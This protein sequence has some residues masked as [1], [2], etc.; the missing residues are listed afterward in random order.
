MYIF[1]CIY[2]IILL[3]K[4]IME[5]VTVMR[6]H[7]QPNAFSLI[8]V[9]PMLSETFAQRIYYS[10]LIASSTFLQWHL[11]ENLFWTMFINI[12][13]Q[14][15]P[16][17][18]TT[19]KISPLYLFFLQE[20]WWE[21]EKHSSKVW[22]KVW[23]SKTLSFSKLSPLSSL[24]PLLHLSVPFTV[25]NFHPLLL[26]SSTVSFPCHCLAVLQMNVII[27]KVIRGPCS[28]WN[29]ERKSKCSPGKTLTAALNRLSTRLTCH[30]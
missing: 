11:N 26:A 16:Y 5:Q 29:W 15:W 20:S 1:L 14:R 28:G 17:W 2:V 8:S 4:K 18:P 10:W 25:V 7:D 22:I 30:L 24:P 21:L 13:S 12:P 6:S 9:I 19:T 27:G 23:N 3:I